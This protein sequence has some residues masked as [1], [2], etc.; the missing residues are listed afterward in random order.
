MT[1]A[2]TLG[3]VDASGAWL[4]D[5]AFPAVP[6]AIEAVSHQPSSQASPAL[7]AAL[8]ATAAAAVLDVAL[9]LPQLSPANRVA[10]WRRACAE[11]S[12][13]PD[14]VSEA[15]SVGVRAAPAPATA[16]LTRAIAADVPTLLA[17]R[18]WLDARWGWRP[19]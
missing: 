13:T 9:V 18:T 10:M 2:L 4:R 5:P 16:T 3:T 17:L 14:L 8:R 12:A 19:A 7:L 6:T 11:A 15:A 1:P